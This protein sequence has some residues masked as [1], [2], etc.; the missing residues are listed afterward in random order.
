MKFKIETL[1]T[2]AIGARE[3]AYAPYSHHPVGAAIVSDSGNV[4]TG[5]N[6]ENAAYPLGTCAERNAVAGM[7]GSD[8]LQRITTVII[9]GPGKHA[10]PPCGGCRQVLREFATDDT[11]I[12]CCDMNGDITLK[13][14]LGELLPH[15]FGPDNLEKE[16]I[17]TTDGA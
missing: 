14:T 4:Y 6:V 16:I 7:I 10:C 2:L 13:T 3:K 17:G 12:I 11:Q 5:C 15:S 1:T 9:A 8:G